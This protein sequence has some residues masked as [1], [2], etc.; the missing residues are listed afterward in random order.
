MEKT[1]WIAGPY[2]PLIRALRSAE[3]RVA[4][5]EDTAK[6]ML[7][8]HALAAASDESVFRV[9][10]HGSWSYVGPSEQFGHLATGLDTSG[11]YVRVGNRRGG[12]RALAQRLSLRYGERSPDELRALVDAAAEAAPMIAATLALRVERGT[13]EWDTGETVME[14]ALRLAR[15]AAYAMTRK[16]SARQVFDSVFEGRYVV[17]EVAAAYLENRAAIDAA[18]ETH[19]IEWDAGDRVL[20]GVQ[21]A[22]RVGTAPSAWRSHV[23]RGQAPA[24]DRAGGWRVTTV[25]A[26]RLTRPRAPK[27]AG[28]R[29]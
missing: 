19:G 22:Q 12:Y 21:A 4:G 8:R 18:L 15:D 3:A 13:V 24:A 9:H 25:D 7:R 28:W 5:Y 17:E 29:E 1:Q 20:S 14:A 16:G 10:G 27:P 2:H 26:W 6:A 23:S 11:G